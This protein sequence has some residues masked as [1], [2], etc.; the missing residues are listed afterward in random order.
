MSKWLCQNEE[1]EL[2]KG[3]E[4]NLRWVSRPLTQN[5]KDKRGDGVKWVAHC[6]TCEAEGR[7]EACTSQPV[8]AS[9]VMR[10]MF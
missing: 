7:C 9:Q 10:T 6:R 2:T 3:S 8:T 1:H 5:E 4:G